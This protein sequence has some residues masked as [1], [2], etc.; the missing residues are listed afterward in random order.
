MSTS[1]PLLARLLITAATLAYGVG[2]FI[3]DM[4]KTHLVHPAWPGHARF[5]LFWAASSQL[6]VAGVALW[7][8]W[9]AGEPELQH[10]R[11]AAYLGLA[12]NSGFFAALVF[13]KYFRGTLNDP[14]GIPPIAGKIDGNILAVLAIVALLLGGLYSLG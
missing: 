3:M 12:M 10:G 4:N 1:V 8:V 13:R 7:L 11:L 9:A 14:Q 2:P 6:A 5:H